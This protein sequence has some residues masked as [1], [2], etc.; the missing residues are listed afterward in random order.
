MFNLATVLETSVRSCPDKTAVILADMRFTYGQ[1]NATANQIANGLKAAGIGKGD[2]VALSCPNLPY[3]PMVYYGILKAGASVVPLNVLF[4]QREI[5]YHLTDSD[6]KAYFCFEGTSELPMAQEAWAAFEGVDSCHNFWVMTADPATP[7]PIAGADT[8]GALLSQHSPDFD[9]VQTMPDDIAVILY[10]SGT[11]GQPKGAALTHSNMFMNALAVRDQFRLTPE[12][13]HLIVLPLF[14][15][16]GQTVQLNAGFLRGNTLVLIPKFDAGAVLNGL[17]QENVTVFCGVP[18]MY[19]GLLH[20]PEADKFDLK[21]IA[22]NLRLG[23]SGGAAM[24]VELMRAFEEKFKIAILEGYGLSETSPVATFNRLDRKRKPGSVGLPIWGV[25]VKVVDDHGISV[26]VNEPGEIVIRGHNVMQGYH[27]C[28]DATEVA[29][30]DGWFHTG[31]IGTMDED[32]YIYIV[33]RLKDMIVRGGYNV[34]PREIEEVLLTHP[35]ISL[36]AVIGVPD[37]KFGEEVKA[38]VV[39]KPGTTATEQKLLDWAK[40]EMASYKYPR[41]IEIRDA[42]PMTATG[43]ILKKELRVG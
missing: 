14:H 13:I 37:D 9:T 6:A 25:E 40:K 18:T 19:W 11:T 10:T 24:P 2:K 8:L 36:A 1:V 15:S 41:I 22:G 33:D 21:K 20:H 26:A 16:F 7:S 30:R 39:L 3:F 17:Q 42:L 29:L 27:K 34:Y 35:A 32:G 38:F 12:D 43:K 28:P 23:V 4:K 5:T 31:D